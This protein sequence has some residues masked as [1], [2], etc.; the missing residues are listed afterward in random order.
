MSISR[1]LSREKEIMTFI[2][3]CNDSIFCRLLAEAIQELSP[4]FCRQMLKTRGLETED[5]SSYW[6]TAMCR[7]ALGERVKNGFSTYEMLEVLKNFG[8][9][10]KFHKCKGVRMLFYDLADD[11]EEIF[12][13]TLQAA[14]F[15]LTRTNITSADLSCKKCCVDDFRLLEIW[16]KKDLDIV[17]SRS[18]RRVLKV[19]SDKQKNLEK[20][21][22]ALKIIPG[23]RIRFDRDASFP[24][25]LIFLIV[26]FTIARLGSHELANWHVEPSR[27]DYDGRDMLAKKSSRGV[28]VFLGDDDEK[29]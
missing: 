14:E 21:L 17:L 26:S 13:H 15:F 9:N 24:R 25:S 27:F 1:R 29:V 2:T 16:Y 7:D 22:S 11:T 19:F 10:P 6:Y 8:A 23:R 20:C 12:E 28:P 4:D 3:G 5:L 18:V